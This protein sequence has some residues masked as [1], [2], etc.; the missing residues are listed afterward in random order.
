MKS[1]N[2]SAFSS[3]L[4]VLGDRRAQSKLLIAGGDLF[5]SALHDALEVRL[6]H[7]PWLTLDRYTGPLHPSPYCDLQ[8]SRCCPEEEF[9]RMLVATCY[10]RLDQPSLAQRVLEAV[11]EKNPRNGRALFHLAYCHRVE[12]R[13]MEALECL[14]KVMPRGEGNVWVR[15]IEG[16]GRGGLIRFVGY[17]GV[18]ALQSQSPVPCFPSRSSTPSVRGYS[19]TTHLLV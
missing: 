14:S 13:S 7:H 15:V 5:K 17:N 3:R 4:C 6:S 2:I 9:Y 18:G 1:N 12:G 19:R 11:L 10:L 8:A 16:G